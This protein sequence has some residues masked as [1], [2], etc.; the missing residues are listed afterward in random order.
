MPAHPGTR[1]ITRQP[2][3]EVKQKLI[4]ETKI[5]ALFPDSVSPPEGADDLPT[6][7]YANSLWTRC[8]VASLASG[9]WAG[10]KRQSHFCSFICCRRL[11][12]HSDLSRRS[13]AGPDV[14]RARGASPAPAAAPSLCA[15]SHTNA[16]NSISWT[17]K[18]PHVLNRQGQSDAVLHFFFF[19]VSLWHFCFLR[20][21]RQHDVIE[22]WCHFTLCC[23]EGISNGPKA[24]FQNVST[25]RLFS[26]LF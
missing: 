8:H 9:K 14:L 22:R 5:W 11:S 7:T 6:H 1:P 15:P 19:F 20:W 12:T 2:N 17:H 10:D 16:L 18:C 24:K 26:K 21:Q 25:E 4:R 13:P 23:W 3:K